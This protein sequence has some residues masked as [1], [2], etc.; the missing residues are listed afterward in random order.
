MKDDD[1]HTVSL[2]TTLAYVAAAAAALI[3]VVC[4]VEIVRSRGYASIY[5][6]CPPFNPHD[7]RG[8]VS[9]MLIGY[10]TAPFQ[11]ERRA[12]KPL[13]PQSIWSDF[14]LR[15]GPPGM[16]TS[17]YHEDITIF[18]EDIRRA[19]G[20]VPTMN[21]FRFGVDWS[22]VE[23][24]E[25]RFDPDALTLY[26]EMV[27]ACRRNRIRPIVTLL[28]FVEPRWLSDR[29]GFSCASSVCAFSRFVEKI[30][31]LFTKNDYPDPDLRPIFVTLN[32]P[33]TYALLA[34]GVGRRPPFVSSF[35]TCLDVICNLVA[36][37]DAAYDILA[38]YGQVTIAKVIMPAYAESESLVE[39]FIAH[40]LHVLMNTAYME[41]VKTNVLSLRVGPIHRTLRTK[42]TIDVFGV[43][44]YTALVVRQT[45]LSADIE[46]TGKTPDLPIC[47]AGWALD[48][49][50][51]TDALSVIHA[52]LGVSI[53][54]LFTE[55]G[56]AQVEEEPDAQAQYTHKCLEILAD[57]SLATG[58]LMGVI[59]WTLVDNF[60]WELGTTPKFGHYTIGRDKKDDLI[61]ALNAF[62][63]HTAVGASTTGSIIPSCASRRT[64]ARTPDTTRARRS[65]RT[66]SPWKHKLSLF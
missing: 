21:A 66:T 57:Y 55:I 22:R 20:D 5:T 34:Y 28:H 43:N 7:S 27:A 35:S 62:A 13:Q 18:E 12:D 4:T 23:P 64:S 40:E 59:V 10:A 65:D 36:A 61:F 41:W 44:H 31:E 49:S 47:A 53:P 24:T 2:T 38:P 50:G 14:V 15:D 8:T 60:E 39:G 46:M 51:L 48:P 16:D 26:T 11:N 29:G 52:T 42:N 1:R 30:K 25:G 17:T 3:A 63:E 33:F 56:A 58:N 9:P 37:H 19:L 32:E 6:A 54:I 45:W